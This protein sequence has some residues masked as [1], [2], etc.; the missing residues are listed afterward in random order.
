MRPFLFDSGM[1][2]SLMKHSDPLETDRNIRDAMAEALEQGL[3]LL[4]EL[5]EADYT[6]PLP[7]AFEATI[8]GH[9]RHCLE[10]FEPLVLDPESELIDYDAR[11]RDRRVET[12]L[13]HA[14]ERTRTLL[15]ACQATPPVSMQRPV[16]TRCKVSYTG[17]ASPVVASTLGREGMYAVAH[18]IH[19]Y[20]LIGVMCHLLEIPIPEGFGIAPS[21]VQ[22]QKTTSAT[23]AA[24]T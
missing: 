23:A 13:S 22:H 24:R 6:T 15:A 18:A 11:P 17:E 20:A 21:T 14:I 4:E 7:A 12:D 9:Y 3:C 16:Q 8:G 19:H 5:T 10:H 2:A 1:E